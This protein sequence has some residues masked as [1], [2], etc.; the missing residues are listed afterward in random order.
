MKRVEIET[1]VA[2]IKAQGVVDEIIRLPTN[3]DI[4]VLVGKYAETISQDGRRTGII[5]HKSYDESSPLSEPSYPEIRFCI[6]K[7][8]LHAFDS[9]EEK[10]KTHQVVVDL[11]EQLLDKEMFDGKRAD[12]HADKRAVFGAIEL[13][14]RYEIRSLSMEN[15][16]VVKCRQT[17]DWTP[18]ANM[19]L[20]PLWV[21]EWAF[22]KK[23]NDY[24]KR[25]REAARLPFFDFYEHRGN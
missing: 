14:V 22:N 15:L 6:V 5:V 19:F 4:G 9:E 24:I 20:V 25:Q 3:I 10:T 17:G 23:Y 16:T 7:E 18:I 13:L 11:M 1:I 8:M 2:A 21:A 12:Y